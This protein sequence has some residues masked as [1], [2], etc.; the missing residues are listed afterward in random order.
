MQRRKDVMLT[1]RRCAAAS[2]ATQRKRPRPVPLRRRRL[3]KPTS[4][5]LRGNALELA[6]AGRLPMVVPSRAGAERLIPSRNRGIRPPLDRGVAWKAA[7]SMPPCGCVREERGGVCLYALQG[8][9]THG[10]SCDA[11]PGWRSRWCSWRWLQS[12]SPALQCC[13]RRRLQSKRVASTTRI[14]SM[15]RRRHWMIQFTSIRRMQTRA[16]GC[17]PLGMIHRNAPPADA[18]MAFYRYQVPWDGPTRL[19]TL[20]VTENNITRLATGATRQISPPWV[21]WESHSASTTITGPTPNQAGMCP[22][23]L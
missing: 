16:S 14:H 5:T 10:G 3:F 18:V 11:A 22:S 6:P 12:L 13:R 1:R 15:L 17:P 23:K 4:G 8:M 2:P 21:R 20:P 7:N 9:S 19:V